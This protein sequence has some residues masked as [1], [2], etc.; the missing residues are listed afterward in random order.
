MTRDQLL[1]MDKKELN[2]ALTPFMG[3]YT[4][5]RLQDIPKE[6]LADRLIEFQTKAVTKTK[7]GTGEPRVAVGMN[8]VVDELRSG[9]KTKEAI[10]KVMVKKQPDR[11][12]EKMAHYVAALIHRVLPEKKF[13]IEKKKGDDGVTYHIAN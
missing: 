10:L 1:K 13:K 7:K 2:Q 11:D 3:G 12:P 5:R 9:W 4:K 6:E 8:I